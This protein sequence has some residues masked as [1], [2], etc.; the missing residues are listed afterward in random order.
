MILEVIRELVEMANS[1]DVRHHRYEYVLGTFHVMAAYLCG[2]GKTQTQRATKVV[3][4]GDWGQKYV[5]II[6]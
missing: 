2:G 1:E 6:G 3:G 4:N 5:K